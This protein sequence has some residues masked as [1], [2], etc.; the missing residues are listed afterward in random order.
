[1]TNY[2]PAIQARVRKLFPELDES[3]VAYACNKITNKIR[4]GHFDCYYIDVSRHPLDNNGYY[5]HLE[6]EVSGIVI[7]VRFTVD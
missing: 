2:F 5:V 3:A 6:V 7:Y 1:M 4:R